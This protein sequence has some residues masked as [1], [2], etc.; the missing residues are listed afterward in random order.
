MSSRSGCKILAILAC[1]TSLMLSPHALL[2]DEASRRLSSAVD[3]KGVRHP[4]TDYVAH[5]P[6]FGDTI[7]TVAPEYPYRERMR[8]HTGS[9]LFRIT[10]DLN[11]GS[12][13]KV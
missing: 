9:G 13:A 7:K 6:W 4:G 11:T 10:L 3:A 12:V 1:M 5:P 8:R 2:A